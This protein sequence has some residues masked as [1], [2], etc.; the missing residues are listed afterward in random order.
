MLSLDE[1][2]STQPTKPHSPLILPDID[3]DSD[4]CQLM[5]RSDNEVL[6]EWRRASKK[7]QPSENVKV[8]KIILV[9]DD[10]SGIAEYMEQ[11]EDG[12]LV[13]I[14]VNNKDGHLGSVRE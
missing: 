3:D 2:N 7:D 5:A 10:E 13:S 14:N 12:T 6:N 4:I 1:L 8:A 9:V 11:K